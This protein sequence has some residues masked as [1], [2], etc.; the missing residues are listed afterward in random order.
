M[1]IR[2]TFVTGLLLI[3]LVLSSCLTNK[4]LTY[5]QYTEDT[6]DMDPGI[7]VAP[8][9]YKVLPNDILFIRLVT[10]DPQW[11]ELFNP[12]VGM[13]GS[14]TQESASLFG[15]NVDDYGYID[16]PYIGKVDVLDKTISEIK[17]DLDQIFENYVT[18]GAVTVR[19]VNNFVSIIGEVR[20]PGR[21]PLAKDRI[22][23][24]EALSLAGDLDDYS[25][26]Q[27][28][29]LI[30]PSPTG[31]LIKEFSL[32]DRSILKSEFYY[33]MPNDIIYAKP[34]RGRNF[35]INAPVYSL[36]LTS[37]TTGLVIISYFR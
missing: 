25:N 3:F 32:R 2:F 36:L 30:R 6:P 20:N 18:D 26:R 11:S 23:V 28:I 31:P 17:S 12:Q 29:Q 4:K 33:V 35:Q 16:I 21:Y 8:S 14:M 1:K 5:L 24:F 22:N 37:I 7:T 34:M 10:P 15:Y 9:A 27:E 19:L 13:G